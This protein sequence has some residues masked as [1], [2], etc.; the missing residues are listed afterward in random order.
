MGNRL[1]HH[2]SLGTR[3]LLGNWLAAT[4]GFV[5]SMLGRRSNR[6]SRLH[7]RD[8]GRS[9]VGPGVRYQGPSHRCIASLPTSQSANASGSAWPERVCSYGFLYRRLSSQPNPVVRSIGRPSMPRGGL[10]IRAWTTRLSE[11]PCTASSR[12]GRQRSWRV[13]WFRLRTGVCTVDPSCQ[14]ASNRSIGFHHHGH[15]DDAP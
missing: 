6:R 8:D 3:R 13:G 7:D 11:C 10:R 2:P 1:H 14:R 4:P 15:R 9:K 5:R 12:S